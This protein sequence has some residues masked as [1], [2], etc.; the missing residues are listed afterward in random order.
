MISSKGAGA[1]K[2]RQESVYNGLVLN[3][4]RLEENNVNMPNP[5]NA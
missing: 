4:P 2:L 5:G 3:R 1:A